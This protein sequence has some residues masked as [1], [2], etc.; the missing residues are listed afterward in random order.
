MK[1]QIETIILE[2]KSKQRLRIYKIE[3]SN[4]FCIG[5]EDDEADHFEFEAADAEE[6]TKAIN[7]VVDSFA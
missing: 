4:S 1:K 2:N 3:N 6:I 7:S 5:L